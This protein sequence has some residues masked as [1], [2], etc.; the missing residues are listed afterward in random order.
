MALTNDRIVFFVKLLL[1][2]ITA[3][4]IYHYWHPQIIL[5]DF[6]EYNFEIIKGWISDGY[7][8][9]SLWMTS[10]VYFTIYFLIG[11][12]VKSVFIEKI[13]K[14]IAQ[15]KIYI[16]GYTASQKQAIYGAELVIKLFPKIYSSKEMK[17]AVSDKSFFDDL[18][19]FFYSLFSFSIH[20]PICWFILGVNNSLPIYFL[21][22]LI[23]VVAIIFITSVF[24][25]KPFIDTFKTYVNNFNQ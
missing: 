23:T 5:L 6:K 12:L 14:K 8:F 10:V 19:R 18:E 24:I 15:N 25:A 7:F 3:Y 13:V 1:S 2:G 20:I 9:N 22:L 17:Q 11:F 16:Y 4:G 21:F